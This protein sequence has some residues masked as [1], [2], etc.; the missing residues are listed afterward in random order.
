MKLTVHHE[1]SYAYPESV[2]NSVNEAWLDP[3]LMS[4]RAA[5]HFG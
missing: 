3:L 2:F 4:A 1:T 5:S